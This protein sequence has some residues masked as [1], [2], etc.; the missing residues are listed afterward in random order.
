MTGEYASGNW[1]V[2][3]GSEDEFI[4]RWHAWL[5]ESTKPIEGF[6]SARL[7][8]DAEDARH[9]VSFSEWANGGA[10]D[11]WKSSEAFATGL[12]GCRELCDEFRGADYS[13][14]ASV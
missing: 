14:S 4:A 2:K 10:R 5:S 12:A 13:E 7:L 8:R 3:A 6:N 9:F 1:V 11:A